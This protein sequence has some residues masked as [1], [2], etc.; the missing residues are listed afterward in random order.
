MWIRN[1]AAFLKGDVGWKEQR[2]QVER[3]GTCGSQRSAGEAGPPGEKMNGNNGNASRRGSEEFLGSW[4]SSL[5]PPVFTRSETSVEHGSFRNRWHESPLPAK[6]LVRN[7]EVEAGAMLLF[8][9][10]TGCVRELVKKHMSG[11]L[12][13]LG[14]NNDKPDGV[15]G[16]YKWS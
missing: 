12:G 15:Q 6:Y 8:I 10:G 4:E 9:N 3:T 7:S 2:M 5:L 11:F 13:N 16:L 14:M 1:S